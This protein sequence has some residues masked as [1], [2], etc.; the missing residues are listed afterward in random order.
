MLT[1]S[2]LPRSSL[3][4]NGLTPASTSADRDATDLALLSEAVAGRIPAHDPRL[5]SSLR[6]LARPG[7]PIER[8][9][10]DEQARRWLEQLLASASAMS[11]ADLDPE[12]LLG[13]LQGVGRP[14]VY[15]APQTGARAPSGAVP[16]R[17][18]LN[19]GSQ[20][21][22]APTGAPAATATPPRPAS[23]TSPTSA[24][25]TRSAGPVSASTANM[26][27]AKKFDHYRGLIEANGGR[28][29]ANGKNVISV[30]TPTNTRTNGG[31]GA[32]D[33]VT[34]V[35]SVGPGGEK[36]VQE[37]RSN[38]DPSARYEGRM[39]VDVDGDGR[40]DQGRLRAGSY[41]YDA[42][43]FRG[44]PAFAMR[45]D[46]IVD[47]DTNHDGNFGNDGGARSGGG[48]S[49]LWHVGGRGMTGSAGCQTMDPAEYQRFLAALGGSRSFRYTVVDR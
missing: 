21:R 48:N 22:P 29:D 16:A 24:T 37:F 28:F 47:R 38:T 31:N 3:D 14:P 40:L 49:M 6:N 2:A 9:L 8:G 25:P 20:P 11:S 13:A 23:S 15:R 36:R 19:T 42:T 26:S 41:V 7:G 43:T 44:G 46:S 27:E 1:A 32:Y 33:D 4:L 45:G 35:L 17:S 18:F 12:A 39:G 10:L 5:V 30:R 34:A